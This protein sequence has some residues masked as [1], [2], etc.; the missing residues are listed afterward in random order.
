MEQQVNAKS[1]GVVVKCCSVCGKEQKYLSR[2]M[3]IKHYTTWKRHGDPNY[4]K[5]EK[6]CSVEGCESEHYGN[7]WC[8]L[9]Y[10]RN[11]VY[12]STDKPVRPIRS[13]IIKPNEFIIHEEYAEIILRNSEG[14]EKCRTKID[15]DDVDRCKEHCWS[16]GKG[17]VSSSKGLRLHRFIMNC[18]DNLVVD[19]IYHDTLDNRKSQ[20][21]ICTGQQNAINQKLRQDNTSGVKGISWCN[22]ANKWRVQIKKHGNRIHIGYFYDIEEARQARIKASEE[23]FGEYVNHENP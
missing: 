11:R 22:Q 7:G 4:Q 14:E 10:E 13:G 2:G 8:K 21:R 6:I 19:H 23:H 18:P 15:L 20:L 12:G 17:Y 5:P 3:C 16:D 1:V 9:H